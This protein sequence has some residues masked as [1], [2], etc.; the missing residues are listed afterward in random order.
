MSG[1]AS[2]ER[3][4]RLGQLVA[5]R[6]WRE[7]RR[8]WYAVATDRKVADYLEREDERKLQIGAGPVLLDGWLNTDRDPPGVYLDA[9]R[10]FPFEDGTFDYVFSE[11]T[12]EHLPYRS[13]LSML[14]ECHRVLKPR[15]KVRIATPD[16][17]R[18]ARLYR[19][20][21]SDRRYVRWS[22][23]TFRS[24]PDA[25]MQEADGY[26]TSFVINNMFR[27]WGHRF[28]Y[29]EVTLR[30]ALERAGFVDVQRFPCG[31]SDDPVL[32]GLE[33]HGIPED[34]DMF[35]LETMVLQASRA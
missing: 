35:L 13:G 14:G 11:H 19:G 8:R 9:T 33:S 27:G 16:L 20:D 1:P 22:I 10:P 34:R 29:D 32:A 24:S 17:E 18:I 2:L 7:G 21:E 4:S 25:A 15:G 30:A 6:L 26:R 31:E 3:W 23:D 5:R 12:I 28:I